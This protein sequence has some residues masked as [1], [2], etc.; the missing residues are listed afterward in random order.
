MKWWAR[1][2]NLIPLQTTPVSSLKNLIQ[3][4]TGLLPRKQALNRYRR[5]R[6]VKSNSWHFQDLYF[7]LDDDQM[8]LCQCPLEDKAT[9]R[10]ERFSGWHIYIRM[11]DGSTTMITLDNPEVWYSSSVVLRLSC[12]M[13]KIREKRVF[14]T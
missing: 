10:L 11:V 2:V 14:G 9:I 5:K 12:A 13:E 6:F 7:P 3:E 8:M 4:R 1:L